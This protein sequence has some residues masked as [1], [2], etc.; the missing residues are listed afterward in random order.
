MKSIPL[1]SKVRCVVSG[2]MGLAITES[3]QLNGNVR[4][5]VQPKSDDG[6]SLPDAWDIDLQSL[7]V[8][9]AGIS[10]H[11]TPARPHSFKTGQKVRDLITGHEGVITEVATYLNGCVFATVVPRKRKDSAVLFDNAPGGSILPIE[12]LEVIGKGIELPK[13]DKPTGGPSLRA[14]RI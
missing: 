9:D 3:H 5:G 8:V 11:V 10:D 12:R 2:V 14:V 6:K 13:A 1:G 7:E 4:Y